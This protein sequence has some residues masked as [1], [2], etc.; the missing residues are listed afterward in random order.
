MSTPIISVQDVSYSYP[1]T[2]KKQ[3]LADINMKVYQGEMIALLGPNGSGKSTLARLLNGLLLPVKGEVIV[4]GLL[5]SDN[6]YTWEIRR[7][8]GMVFQNPDNQLVAALVEEE[9]AFGMENL[10]ISPEEMKRR[11]RKI[12]ERMELSEY[13]EFPPHRLSGGQ[14]QRVAIASVLALEPE[15]LVLDEPTSMLDPGGRKRVMLE[16]E[17]LKQRGTTIVLVTHDMTEAVMADRVMV[18]EQGKLAFQGSPVQCFSKIEWLRKIGLELPPA[19]E[20]ARRLKLKGL[21]V[22]TSPL[23]V[24][25]WIEYLCPQL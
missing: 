24:S 20:L 19:T 14:K 23:H 22:P 21:P 2:G 3:A 1:E 15:V 8:V 12:S 17:R 7:K 16:L 18:L 10:G 9:L 11:I 4:D 6:Q 13:L 25:D 5:S